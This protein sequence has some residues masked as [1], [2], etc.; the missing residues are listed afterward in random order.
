MKATCTLKKIKEKII[1]AD[2]IT[3]KNLS[4]PILHSVLIETIDS[5]LV[6]RATNLDLGVEFT[7]PASIEVKGKVAVS[8]GILSGVLSTLPDDVNVTLE[9]VNGNLVIVT[10]KTTTVVNGVPSEDFPTLP[11]VSDGSDVSIPADVFVSGVRSVWYSAANTD[12][13]PEFSSVY[14]YFDEGY[15]VF[16]STDSFRLAEKR[17][18]VDVTTD[19]SGV[20]LPIKNVNEVIKILSTLKGNIGITFDSNQ[21]SF[22][23]DGVYV[24]SRI[25]NGVYPDYRQI[26]PSSFSTKATLLKD[27]VVNA[28]KLTNILSDK[29]HKVTCST[30]S[31]TKSIDLSSKNSGVGENMSSIDAIIEGDDFSTNFNYRYILDGFQSI[32]QDSVLFQF[33]QTKDV[34]II[35]GVGDESFTYLV[36]PMNK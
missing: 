33:D 5:A 27:T 6:I 17:I 15:V 1:Q 16:V 28:L 31:E 26:I 9:V 35:Q 32:A 24:I 30:R 4:L 10:E 14:M 29:F 8:G 36:K 20:I 34:L 13:K 22:S 2:R 19:V 11:R 18:K 7:I 21:I 23:C 3:G 12:I 25:V